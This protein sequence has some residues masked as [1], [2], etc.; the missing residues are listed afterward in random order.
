MSAE[1]PLIVAEAAARFNVS[2]HTV[3]SWIA[4]GKLGYVKL[5]RAVRIPPTEIQRVLAGGSVP[6]SVPLTTGAVTPHSRGTSPGTR[7]G[8]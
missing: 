7:A 2:P 6:A 3:R 4:Q 8:G 1:T 5:G